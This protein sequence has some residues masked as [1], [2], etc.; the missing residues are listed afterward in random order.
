[1]LFITEPFMITWKYRTHKKKCYKEQ[2]LKYTWN[3]MKY[4]KTNI[5][6]EDLYDVEK[7]VGLTRE[8]NK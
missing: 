2:Q 6:I 1:M 4:A 8:T 3:Q 5:K 7:K